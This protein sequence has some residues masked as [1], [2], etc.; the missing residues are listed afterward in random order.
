M[1]MITRLTQ[2]SS[3]AEPVQQPGRVHPVHAEQPEVQLEDLGHG[4]NPSRR[5]TTCDS[6]PIR[7]SGPGTRPG[8][9]TVLAGHGGG[10]GAVRPDAARAGRGRGRP[11]GR[12]PWPEGEQYD[13]ELLA[14]R[15]PAQRGRPLPLLDGRGDR[16]RPRHPAARLPRRHRELAARLQ[17]RH[18]RAHRQR[19]PRRRGA[20]RG[21]PALEPARRDG[22][23]PLPARRAPRD[24]R[25][26]RGVPPRARRRACSASTTCPG[27]RAPG[28]DGACRGGCASCSARRVRGSPRRRARRCDGTF[29]IAQFGSTRSINASAAAAI[30]MHTWVRAV[31]RPRRRRGLAGLS[32][33]RLRPLAACRLEAGPRHDARG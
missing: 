26:P 21:Q 17:H 22:H 27:S 32:G 10:A 4:R 11:L 2:N 7:A 1:K 33:R 8:I 20:H 25:R 16:R 9:G 24:R 14:R 12:A 19:V 30:A 29:S 28:D 5:P 13:A 31:R 18:D 15:R 3:V 23:R 6:V